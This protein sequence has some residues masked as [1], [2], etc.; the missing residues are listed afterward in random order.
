[1]D[2]QCFNSISESSGYYEA[3]TSQLT[4]TAEGNWKV[5]SSEIWTCTF[6]IPVRRSTYWANESIGMEGASSNPARV[7]FSVAF[8]S[9][10]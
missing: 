3:K 2:V 1:M 6:G 4:Y 5:D 10:G 7:N 8:G 9:V